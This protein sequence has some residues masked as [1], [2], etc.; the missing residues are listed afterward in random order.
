MATV[1]G[2]TAARMKEIEDAAIIDGA[3][4]LDDLILTRYDAAEIN[5]GNV[6]GPQGIQG[7]PGP[8]SIEVVTSTTRPAN[9]FVGL[10]IYETDRHRLYSWDGTTWIYRGGV[11]LCLS[12]NRPVTNTIGIIIYETDTNKFYVW[13][14]TTWN[15]PKNVAGGTLGTPGVRT[16]SQTGIITEVDLINLATT[17][18][19]GAGRRIKVSYHMVTS[20]T[21]TDGNVSMR[22]KE[23]TVM[24]L[25]NFFS[26]SLA[27]AGESRSGFVLLTPTAGVH[28]YKL[29]MLRDTGTGTV[30]LVADP[31][32]PASIIAED[33]GSV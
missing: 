2:Y 26:N 11:I 21:I 22:I 25:N 6:R 30:A 23:G 18:T 32:F 15:L 4:V 12:T 10:M 27:N 28:T 14:G 24:L 29:T 17:I 5:A 16:A 1:T 7:P 9:P 8:T 19:V 13:D 20:R 31:L 3:V 33:I